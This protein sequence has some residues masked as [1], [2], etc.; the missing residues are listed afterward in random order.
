MLIEY[1][2]EFL[3]QAGELKAVTEAE[4]KFTETLFG[5]LGEALADQFAATAGEYGIRRLERIWGISAASG[6]SLEERRFTVTARLMEKMPFTMKTLRQ[7]LVNLFGE[8]GF[9]LDLNPG[10]Y[11]LRVLARRDSASGI[12]EADSL[13]KRFCPANLTVILSVRYARHFELSAF[14]HADLAGKT[15]FEIKNEVKE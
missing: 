12:R 1:L 5:R 11:T 10:R 4:E 6:L 8:D 13:L 7:M 9:I 15:H 2:P 3:R 14:A